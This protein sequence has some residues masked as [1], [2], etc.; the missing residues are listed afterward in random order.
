MFRG[1]L[2]QAQ[3]IDVSAKSF[4][5]INRYDSHDEPTKELDLG[6]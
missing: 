4:V 1:T 3:V 6:F 2:S 5:L